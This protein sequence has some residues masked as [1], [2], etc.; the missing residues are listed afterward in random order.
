M[1]IESSIKSVTSNAVQQFQKAH[2]LEK[3]SV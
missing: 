3:T 2:G 1:K